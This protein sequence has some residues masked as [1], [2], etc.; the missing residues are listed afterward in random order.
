M[1]RRYEPDWVHQHPNALWLDSDGK[2][3][4]NALRWLSQNT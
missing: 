2:E 3:Q 4:T 1:A